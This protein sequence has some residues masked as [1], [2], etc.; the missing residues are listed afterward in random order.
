MPEDKRVGLS[1][2][3]GAAP[4]LGKDN[5]LSAFEAG[6]EIDASYPD[7]YLV[8]GIRQLDEGQVREA[9][10]SFERFLAL[11]PTRRDEVA[12]WIERTEPA[13]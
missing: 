8:L 1:I 5:L 7:L 9:R 3:T 11:A 10:Q 6:L 4:P 13:P 2:N 12:I